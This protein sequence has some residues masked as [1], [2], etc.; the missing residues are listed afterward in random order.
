MIN[1]KSPK[2]RYISLDDS[3]C[4]GVF[5]LMPTAARLLLSDTWIG[6]IS[7]SGRWDD[8]LGTC[9]VDEVLGLRARCSV[10]GAV[11]LLARSSAV[12]PP[13][14][15][16][17]NSPTVDV[18]DWACAVASQAVVGGPWVG[19]RR[20]RDGRSSVDVRLTCTT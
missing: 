14:V 16:S 12:A 1:G 8:T 2:R 10:V 15:L 18:T 7:G 11:E 19:V 9:A 13:C 17:E 3:S 6:S 5:S 4:G 20:S